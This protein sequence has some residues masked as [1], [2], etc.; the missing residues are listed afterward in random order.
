MNVVSV[1]HGETEYFTTGATVLYGGDRVKIETL[2]D[3]KEES[4]K[5]IEELLKPGKTKKA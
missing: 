3:D 4:L 2:T 5:D 1:L